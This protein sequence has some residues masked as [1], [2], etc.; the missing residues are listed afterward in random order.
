MKKCANCKKDKYKSEFNKNSTKKDGLQNRCRLCQNE[1]DR[2]WHKN[3]SKRRLS[4][5]N[6]RLKELRTWILDLKKEKGCEKCI[7]NDPICL[8]F[9]HKKGNKKLNISCMVAQGFGK[10]K[11]LKEVKKCIVLCSNCHR[12]HHFS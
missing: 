9:H 12:K 1:Y 6:N 7:E 3:N 4:K 5:K 11:I 8:D 10:D 2:N